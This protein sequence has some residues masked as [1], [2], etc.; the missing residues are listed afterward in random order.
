[1]RG[2]DGLDL[3]KAVGKAQGCRKGEVAVPW[4]AGQRYGGCT[5]SLKNSK[6]KMCFFCSKAL[7]INCGKQHPFKL[8]PVTFVNDLLSRSNFSFLFTGDTQGEE[9]EAMHE[10]QSHGGK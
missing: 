7:C 9:D 6:G 1:M 4:S 8:D 10:E 3:K 2:F 5:R